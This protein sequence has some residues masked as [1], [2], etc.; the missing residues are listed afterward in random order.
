M[1]LPSWEGKITVA[2]G[3]I[4][5]DLCVQEVPKLRVSALCVRSNTQSCIHKFGG[6][7][8]KFDQLALDSPKGCGIILLSVP[9]KS[10]KV[11][12]YFGKALGAPHSHTK[13]YIC[14][15]GRSSSTQEA[16]GSAMATKTTPDPTLF[17]KRFLKLEKTKQT[18]NRKKSTLHILLVGV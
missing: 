16:D 3:I 14:F 17:L 15:K 1:K 11:S 9:L 10:Q 6:K 5:Y 18:K 7:I 4:T 8:L 13:P 2:V 12:R